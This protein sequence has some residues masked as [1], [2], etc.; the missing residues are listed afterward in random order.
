MTL[1]VVVMEM[2]V[3][4]VLCHRIVKLWACGIIGVIGKKKL[5]IF[6]NSLQKRSPCP[7]PASTN[8]M[9][10]IRRRLRTCSPYRDCHPMSMFQCNGNYSEVLPCVTPTM[11]NSTNTTNRPLPPPTTPLTINTGVGGPIVVDMLQS[12]RIIASG[13]LSAGLVQS[14]QINSTG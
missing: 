6:N 10:N 12:A 1:S 14:M 9:L 8:S 7:S 3:I 13:A 4:L 11:N 5:E 2:G